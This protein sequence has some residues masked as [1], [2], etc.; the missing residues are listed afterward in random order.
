MI[1]IATADDT[2]YLLLFVHELARE[3]KTEHEVEADSQQ[4]IKNIFGK[5]TTSHA[6]ICE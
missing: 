4:M 5:N 2:N 1:R 6:V 3:E